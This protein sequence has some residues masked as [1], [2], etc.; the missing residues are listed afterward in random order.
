MLTDKE[1]G[2]L[3]GVPLGPKFRLIKERDALKRVS[4]HR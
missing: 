3:V 2:E 1:M 4:L